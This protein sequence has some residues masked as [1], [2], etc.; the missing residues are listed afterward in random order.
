MA[1]SI[2]DF[3]TSFRTELARPSRFDV[4][5]PIPIGLVDL[6]KSELFTFRCEGA[7]LPG[8]ALATTTQKIYGPEEKFPYQTTYNDINMTFICTENMIEKV[9]FDQWLNIINPNDS[10]DIKYK[11]TYVYRKNIY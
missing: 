7:D 8:R 2:A 10:Y 4:F 5:I 6:F 11:N 1:G 3:K 9:F